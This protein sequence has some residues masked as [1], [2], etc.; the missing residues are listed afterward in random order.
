MP[1]VMKQIQNIY[2]NKKNI[3]KNFKISLKIMKN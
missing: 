3:M 1:R 2:N